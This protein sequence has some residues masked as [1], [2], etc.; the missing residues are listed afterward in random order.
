MVIVPPRNGSVRFPF[1]ARIVSA[2]VLGAVAGHRF[3]ARVGWL[4][5]F[6]SVIIDVIKALAGPLL[7]FAVLDAFLRTEVRLRSAWLMVAI[8]LTNALI[9]VSIGL[10]LSNLLRP[11]DHLHDLRA[12]SAPST[13]LPPG[14]VRRIDIVREIRS[15]LPTN[16]VQPFLE[17]SVIT[18]VVLAVLTGGALRFVKNE[19]IRAGEDGYRAVED[20]V[21]TLF[22]AI[23]VILGW[24]IAFVP[25]A[26]FG[27]VASTIGRQGFEPVKGL[28]WYLGVAILG[29]AVHVLVVYQA[30]V[31]LVARMSLV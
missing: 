25:V 5:E 4:G 2:M 21:L 19:Q 23:E 27:V 28:V 10:T 14:Q 24:V 16:V 26:V 3:G 9:A 29:L 30:W 17:N 6:G 20:F 22:R 8:S 12:A 15:Y 7:F 18:I 13:G 1:V 31:V 11:G